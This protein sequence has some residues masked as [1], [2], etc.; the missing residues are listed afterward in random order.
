MM[1]EPTITVWPTVYQTDKEGS[2]FTTHPINP[3]TLKSQD[4]RRGGDFM[5]SMLIRM[6]DDDT[7]IHEVITEE[8]DAFY[9]MVYNQLLKSLGETN[10]PLDELDAC[11]LAEAIVNDLKTLPVETIGGDA[12][13]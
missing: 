12:N 9:V 1:S 13:E 8:E 4:K 5:V 3:I 2:V 6:V 10:V 7:T 11:D